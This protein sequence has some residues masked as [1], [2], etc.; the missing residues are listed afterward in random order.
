MVAALCAGCLLPARAW[1][2]VVPSLGSQVDDQDVAVGSIEVETGAKHDLIDPVS[3]EMNANE[4]RASMPKNYFPFSFNG[5]LYQSRAYEMLAL[6]NRERASKG[7]APLKWDADLES[8]AVTRAAETSIMFSHLRPNGSDCFTAFPDGLYYAGENIAMGFS[9]VQ[10]TFNQW[11][12]SSGHYANMMNPN[13]T[14]IGISCFYGGAY[15]WCWVQTFGGRSGSANESPSHMNGAANVSIGLPDS[16]IRSATW[17]ANA[18]TP[19]VGSMRALPSVTV[20]FNGVLNDGMYQ[21]SVSGDVTYDC[22]KFFWSTDNE[23]V[24]AFLQDQGSAYA[25]G[26]SEGSTSYTAEFPTTS[27]LDKKIPVTVTKTGAFTDVVV[28][29]T[30]HWESIFWLSGSGVTAGYNDGSFRPYAQVARCDMAAFLRR[31]ARGMNVSDAATWKPSASDWKRFSDVTRTTP[32]AEDVLWLA[33]AGIST[34]FPN[35]TFAP[36]ANVARC[37]MAAFLR[38]LAKLSPS[39]DA[40]TWT[41]AEADW[42]AFNDVSSK[43]DH[44]EDILWLRHAEITLGYPGNLYKPFGK[45]ARCDMAAF[46]ERLSAELA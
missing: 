8:S 40:G 46:L 33:H 5:T 27:R 1:A 19:G 26:V 17:T 35:G 36:Y 30:D 14:H 45:V 22:L 13:F 15:G 41:P 39:S 24:A 7:I 23:Q 32:H 12:N 6:V 37:D 31:L 34:G 2:D 29:K 4:R 21:T 43:T 18:L 42:L 38:R 20:S 16:I 3:V 9:S 44:A 10:D 28:P 11:K 25:V